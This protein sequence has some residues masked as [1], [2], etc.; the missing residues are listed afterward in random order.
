MME[1]KARYGTTLPLAN[2]NVYLRRLIAALTDL[3]YWPVTREGHAY[4]LILI[5]LLP[6]LL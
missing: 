1:D 6:I 5:E 4:T 3:V 2:R